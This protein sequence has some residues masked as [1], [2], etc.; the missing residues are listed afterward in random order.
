[1]IFNKQS[2]RIEKIIQSSKNLEELKK[3]SELTSYIYILTFLKN[4]VS[5]NR[6]HG[7][8]LQFQIPK[9]TQP[10][11]QLSPLKDITFSLTIRT[12]FRHTHEIS[13]SIAS[14]PR[15]IEV[16][17]SRVIKEKEIKCQEQQ[18][19]QFFGFPNPKSR[20]EETRRISE[21]FE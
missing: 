4:T 7:K 21:N 2:Y 16:P 17:K 9:G 1:M 5:K 19:Q 14:F 20:S 15:E 18:E 3:K 6:K 10:S 11:K 8:P 12:L 13:N